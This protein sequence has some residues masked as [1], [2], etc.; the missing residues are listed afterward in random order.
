MVRLKRMDPK[1]AARV[2]AGLLSALLHVIVLVLIAVSGSRW[3]GFQESAMPALQ[4]ARLDLHVAGRPDRSEQVESTPANLESNPG[5]QFDSQSIEPLSIPLVENAPP[6]ADVEETAF[7]D[8]RIQDVGE[9]ALN[10][11]IDTASTFVLAQVQAAELLKRVE[12]LAEELEDTARARVSWQQDGRR[13]DAELVLEPARNGVELERAIADVSSEHDGRRLRTRISLRRLPFSH[14][15]QVIDRWDPMVQL[16][17]D[18]IVGRMHINSRFNVLYDSQAAP[19]LL[20][21][22]TTTARGFNV[23]RRGRRTNSNVFPEGIETSARRIPFSERRWSFEQARHDTD[24]RVHELTGDTRIRFLGDSG[25]WWH[26]PASG[27]SQYAS[28]PAGQSVYF[29][30][31]RGATVYLRGVVSGKFLIHSPERIVVE[32]DTT[33]AR[34]PRSDP[35]SRDFLGLVCDGDI[36]VAPPGVTGPGDLHIQA[37]LFASR[38]IVVANAMHPQP[39][40]LH[41]FGSVAAGRLLESEPRYALRLEYDWRFEQLRPPGFPSMNRFAAENWNGEWTEAPEGP[42]PSGS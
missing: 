29:L 4:F 6:R 22:V 32:G 18:E 25:Y 3:D 21:K 1:T 39:S 28:Q 15:A 36:E 12:R 23:E 34:D 31:P 11:A 30:A 33:Y 13:Y 40:T 27:S 26:D 14:F 9:P 19:K 16:H 37:A 35:E 8:A 41:I 20:G 7:E 38:R 2:T 10:R 5:A 42:A 24:V 17:D